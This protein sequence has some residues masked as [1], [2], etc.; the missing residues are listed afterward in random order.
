MNLSFQLPPV[1]CEAERAVPTTESIVWSQ[2]SVKDSI[3][4]F[5]KGWHTVMDRLLGVFLKLIVLLHTRRIWAVPSTRAR[6]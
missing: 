5:L 3:G 2:C 4:V 6:F 1:L